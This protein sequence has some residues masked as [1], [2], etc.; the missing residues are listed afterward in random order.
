MR[1]DGGEAL[2]PSEFVQAAE[3]YNR[4]LAVDKW[5]VDSALHWMKE[6]RQS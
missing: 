1:D 4:M 6:T 5:V 3:R 2:P